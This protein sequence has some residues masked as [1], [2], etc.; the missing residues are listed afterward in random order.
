[1]FGLPDTHH[2]EVQPTFAD[3]DAELGGADVTNEGFRVEPEELSA[4]SDE[5]T[6]LMREIPILH[7]VAETSDWAS[8]QIALEP[9]P[10]ALHLQ[11]SIINELRGKVSGLD[12]DLSHL[13]GLLK[14]NFPACAAAGQAIALSK[15][16]V[17]DTAPKLESAAI[18]AKWIIIWG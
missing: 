14:D 17:F 8:T 12:N 7:E 9:A 10:V 18:S 6:L 2:R 4:S 13:T 5:D 3:P 1:M 15:Q 16:Q 11:G